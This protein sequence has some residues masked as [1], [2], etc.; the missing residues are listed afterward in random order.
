MPK[1]GKG[2]GSTGLDSN[3]PTNSAGYAPGWCGLHV[4]QHQKP[5]PATDSYTLNVS[6]K[7]DNE[8]EIGNAASGP[9]LSLG[10][11]LPYT[12]E[13]QTHNVDADAVTFQYAGQSWDSN[14][15]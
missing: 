7:D 10:S 15:R 9:T 5:N 12:V 8:N 4:V 6:L 13:I 1:I 3:A 2:Q 11:K 14:D